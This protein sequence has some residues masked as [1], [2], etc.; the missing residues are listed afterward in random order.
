MKMVAC[1]YYEEFSKEIW[2]EE[3]IQNRVEKA[4]RFLLLAVGQ[5]VITLEDLYSRP[6]W[7]Y[8]P[9]HKQALEIEWC[10][11]KLQY[12]HHKYAY[13]VRNSQ[14]ENQYEYQ[15]EV[16]EDRVSQLYTE[17]NNDEEVPQ[18]AQIEKELDRFYKETQI[19]FLLIK[20][21]F[22]K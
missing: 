11:G 21:F 18:E 14:G 4:F 13:K 9:S 17:T 7:E 5:E 8:V 20:I 16:E 22:S 12:M 3:E 10:I 6:Y 15:D 2:R 19:I 1:W